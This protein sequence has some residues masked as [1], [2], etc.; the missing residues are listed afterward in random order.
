MNNI[1]N[2]DLCTGCGT[3]KNVCPKQAIDLFEYKSLGHLLPVINQEKCVDC[4]MCCKICPVNTPPK[5]HTPKKVYA[6]WNKDEVSRQTSTSGGIADALYS[7]VLMK[8]GIG[9]GAA[10]DSNLNL[11]LELSNQENQ[12]A[13]FKNSK[14]CQC[15][16]QNIY[17]DVKRYLQ[18]GKHVL[19]IGTPCQCAGIQ[20][21][22]NQEEKRN[23]FVVDLICHGV[24]S[25]KLLKDYVSMINK[26]KA[27]EDEVSFRSDEGY[28][29]SVKR[30]G[31]VTYSKHKFEDYYLTLF[32]KG[33]ICRESCYNCQYACSERVSDITIGDF[34]GIGKEKEFNYPK[35]KVSCVLVNTEKGMALLNECDNLFLV[36]RPISEAVKGNS[37]LHVPTKKNI[38]YSK[39]ISNYERYGLRK[40][41]FRS[42]F[43]NVQLKRISQTF[44]RFVRRLK[45][46]IN[47]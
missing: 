20:N 5:K 32:L 37:K 14:Y 30:S 24:P 29:F 44:W 40:A 16:T 18:Q 6:A 25:N 3:C 10:F 2:F 9:V 33:F 28:V 17:S 1:C 39:F 43:I 11:N 22:V 47:K 35:K 31:R 19:F 12:F 42:V 36:E 27:G 4:G 7:K 15:N 13:R 34:W 23:L 38:A 45:K 41:I 8:N 21:Y 46:I 26:K